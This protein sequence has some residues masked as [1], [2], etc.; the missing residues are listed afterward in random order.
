MKLSGLYVIYVHL[1]MNVT[2]SKYIKSLLAILAKK[3]IT[4]S[5]LCNFVICTICASKR[6]RFV[7]QYGIRTNKVS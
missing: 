4:L 3:T 6:K 7:L 5:M 2:E 1:N